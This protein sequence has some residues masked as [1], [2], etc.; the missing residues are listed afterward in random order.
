MVGTTQL[1][2]PINQRNEGSTERR[3]HAEGGQ[4]A[5]TD[6][7]TNRPQV[8]YQMTGDDELVLWLIEPL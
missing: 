4:E 6:S 8:P 3:L 2:D 5:T 1:G 7:P